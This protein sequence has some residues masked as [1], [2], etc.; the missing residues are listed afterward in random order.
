MTQLLAPGF[1][2]APLPSQLPEDAGAEVIRAATGQCSNTTS[3]SPDGLEGR[4][5][6]AQV[7]QEALLF[8]EA[9]HHEAPK[10]GGGVVCGRDL[11]NRI[12]ALAPELSPALNY[13]RWDGDG[14]FATY[15]ISKDN[16][17][18]LG[19]IVIFARAVAQELAE[20]RLVMHRAS[21]D[22]LA[23]GAVLAGAVLVLGHNYSARA[24][25][26]KLRGLGDPSQATLK[27]DSRQSR[28]RF[29]VP[30]ADDAHTLA[31]SSL[32]VLDILAGLEAARDSRWLDYKTFDV[33]AWQ[34]LRQKFDATWLVPG[35]VLA[36]GHPVLTAQNPAFPGLLGN[37]KGGA[38]SD[39]DA[40]KAR[41]SE[42]PATCTPA[43]TPDSFIPVYC[44]SIGWISTDENELPEAAIG[45]KHTEV[46]NLQT[47]SFVSYFRRMGI[48]VLAVL[49]FSHECTTE[50]L[51]SYMTELKILNYP[52]RDASAPSTVFAEEFVKAYQQHR[53]ESPKGALAV[54]CKAGLGRTGAMIGAYAAMVHGW[55]GGAFLGWARVCRPGSVQTQSQERFLRG[56]G[57]G[58]LVATSLPTKS[59]LFC[60]P[61][62]CKGKTPVE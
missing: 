47:H 8:A 35:E 29:P 19:N 2:W 28:W 58:S 32:T 17:P 22:R 30:F 14:H 55:E 43:S 53:S 21:Q 37:A 24:A 46:E 16:P 15:Q 33:Q 20:G 51:D 54:H 39:D 1:I 12:C 50:N 40:G 38:W 56:F 60:L 13:C 7:V 52:F 36:I 57:S 5:P 31:D 48:D 45:A 27:K 44:E 9:G 34:F 18:T 26:A 23:C 11:E 49:N 25:W 6:T 59:P 62:F 3:W 41:L 61:A 42:T 4:V 10:S